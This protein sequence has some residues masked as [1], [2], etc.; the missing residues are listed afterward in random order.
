MTYRDSDIMKRLAE[1]QKKMRD[2]ASRESIGLYEKR[3]R[4]T[5]GSKKAPRILGDK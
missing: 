3:I 2:K 4:Q 5:P 1:L